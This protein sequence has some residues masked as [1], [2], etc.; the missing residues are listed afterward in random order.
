MKDT[1][2][3]ASKVKSFYSSFTFSSLDQLEYIYHSDIEFTDP[4]HK[5]KGLIALKEYFENMMR[6]T[7][8]CKFD[9]LD[10]IETDSQVCL[11]WVMTFTHPSIAS[12]NTISVDGV[13]ILEIDKSSATVIKHRDYYD[14][15][16]MIYEHLPVLGFAVKKIKSRMQS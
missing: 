15:G 11:P 8:E 2:S 16:A 5:V 10:M 3:V 6:Q 7:T 14:M 1:V 12:G 13:S 4:I 9:F